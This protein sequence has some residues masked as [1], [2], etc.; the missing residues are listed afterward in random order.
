[1]PSIRTA[2]LWSKNR[3]RLEKLGRELAQGLRGEGG[4]E[5]S[6][7]E[8]SGQRFGGHWIPGPENGE[9][10]LGGPFDDGQGCAG[11]D[12]SIRRGPGIAH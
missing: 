6:V 3:E 11:R 7:A 2:T 5:R 8:H 10:R 4:G 9:G 12:V 1:M